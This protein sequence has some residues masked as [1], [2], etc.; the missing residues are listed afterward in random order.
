MIYAD[1]SP[2]AY[3][4][5]QGFLSSLDDDWADL[6]RGLGE[7][8]HQAKPGREPFEALVRAVAYQQVHARTGDAVLGRLLALYPAAEFP[9]PEQL[10]MTDPDVQRSCGFS[11]SKL[12]AIRGIALAATEGVVPTLEEAKALSDEALIERLI[13][14]RGVGRWTIEMLLIY[15]LE[16]SDILPADDFGVREGYRRLKRLAKA[17]TAREMK[18]I[19]ET[20][21]PYRTFASWYLWRVP[22]L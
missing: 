18:Q 7:C 20:W 15:S 5:A 2:Q 14:L 3:L 22:A 19:G 13:T 9:S 1:L 11:A 17:P 10:L 6:V 12:A 8:G 16:R 4:S 21:S